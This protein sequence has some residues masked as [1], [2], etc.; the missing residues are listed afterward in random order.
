MWNLAEIL[1]E[2]L[3]PTLLVVPCPLL[4]LLRECARVESSMSRFAPKELASRNEVLFV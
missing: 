3:I 4:E 2:L 1:L